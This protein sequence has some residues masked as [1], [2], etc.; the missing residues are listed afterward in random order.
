[1]SDA[2]YYELM[3][4][5]KSKCM[6]V[7]DSGAYCHARNDTLCKNDSKCHTFKKKQYKVPVENT[8]FTE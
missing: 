1:M 6:P 8:I 3:L 7:S 2:T 4:K 5:Y